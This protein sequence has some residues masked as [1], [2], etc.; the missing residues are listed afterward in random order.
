MSRDLP[1]SSIPIRSLDQL[2]EYFVEG[3]KK[4]GT[5]RVGME[6]EK[7]ILHSDTM[8]PAPYAG[9]RGIQ[10]L[11]QE[12][13]ARFSYEPQY[14]GDN[15]VAATRR[16]AQGSIEALTIEPGGQFELS[17]APLDKMSDIE[18]EL[19]THMNEVKAICED[20]D[21]IAVPT[22]NNGLHT[23][24]D[25]TWMPKSR[26]K[27]MRQYMTQV[28]TLGH[29]MMKST[30]TVQANY[31]YTSEQDA[32]DIL[33]T[34]LWLSPIVSAIFARSPLLHGKP[35]GYMTTRCYFWTDTD[36]DRC[37]F[38]SFMHHGED[39]GFSDYVNW[40]LD[41]PMYMIRRDNR[42]IDMAGKS[43]RKFIKEGYE[44]TSAT[45]GDYELHLS[46][47][48][49]EV[50]MKR[51]IEVR[52]ADAGPTDFMLGLPALWKGIFYDLQARKD[53]LALVKDMS[54]P[55]REQLFTNAIRFSL[56]GAVP[57]TGDKNQTLIG[58]LAA[59]LIELAAQGLDRLAVDSEN[60]NALAGPDEKRYLQ[61]LRD[62][63]NN[64]HGSPAHQLLNQWHDLQGDTQQWFAN[65][66]I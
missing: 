51:Y 32:V 25:I 63:V 62:A 64:P 15:V 2:T 59:Q 4:P 31:D 10:G 40:T 9:P 5:Q 65:Q 14:D 55:Q 54:I 11:F 44:G 35:S 56:K 23:L 8:K 20:R 46:T 61:P 27:I 26:Y 37:G 42:P 6:H 18:A 58:E 52:G 48:F 33:R 60:Q 24:D 49:P 50:R 22:G 7:F 36:N 43:F 28:G 57:G 29:Y 41:V 47:V 16:N 39:F 30:C 38:P 12:M 66:A 34:G 21:L 19:I 13:V 45:M 53:A 3:I 1:Q 17:G